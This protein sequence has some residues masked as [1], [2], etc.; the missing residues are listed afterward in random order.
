MLNVA[1]TTLSNVSNYFSSLYPKLCDSKVTSVAVAAL[2][3]VASTF[4]FFRLSHVYSYTLAGLSVVALATAFTLFY[5]LNQKAEE[6]TETTAQDTQAQAS[7]ATPSVAPVA[8]QAQKVST[9]GWVLGYKSAETPKAPEQV[10]APEL[11]VVVP[12]EKKPAA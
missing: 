2:S 7:A 11:R 12:A 3:L 10:A 8:V 5:K 1:T 4:S 9:L 6:K